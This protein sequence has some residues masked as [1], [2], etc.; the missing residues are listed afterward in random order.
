MESLKSVARFLV[1]YVYHVKTDFLGVG[2]NDGS[3][4]DDDE[5]DIEEGPT[6]KS[7]LMRQESE[8]ITEQEISTSGN[9]CHRSSTYPNNLNPLD[10]RHQMHRPG[11]KVRCLHYL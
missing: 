7:K 10:E 2:R 1:G 4:E 3:D 5:I 9:Y 8:D 6:E 11:I